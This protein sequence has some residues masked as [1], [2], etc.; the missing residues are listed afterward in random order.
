MVV[1]IYEIV[2]AK[3]LIQQTKMYYLGDREPSIS[4]G[5]HRV[6]MVVGS[7]FRWF[8]MFVGPWINLTASDLSY[9]CFLG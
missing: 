2:I 5:I 4:A 8:L 9:V 6:Y 3:T 7:K 1:N